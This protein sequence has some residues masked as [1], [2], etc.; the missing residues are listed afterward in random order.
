VGR[1]PHPPPVDILLTFFLLF[2]L[3]TATILP[4]LP[5][6]CGSYPVNLP[7]GM[8][9]DITAD[10]ATQG[11]APK[12]P[13]PSTKSAARTKKAAAA[14][15]ADRPTRTRTKTAT[16]PSTKTTQ[17]DNL[18][19]GPSSSSSDS[20]TSEDP[21][22]A[23]QS[24]PE[25]EDVYHPTRQER[26]LSRRSGIGPCPGPTSRRLQV[27]GSHWN[28]F[29]LPFVIRDADFNRYM[30]NCS[31]GARQEA[32]VLYTATAV[33]GLQL[34][35]CYEFLES[36]PKIGREAREHLE[37]NWTYDF[38]IHEYL[39]VRLGII[40]GLQGDSQAQALAEIQQAQVR[41]LLGRGSISA[42]TYQIYIP[43]DTRAKVF[44]ATSRKPRHADNRGPGKSKNP[45]T[46]SPGPSL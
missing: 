24:D 9:D 3:P 11:S 28:S 40:E 26:T 4:G 37:E 41:P 7:H 21:N 17:L 44:A 15:K 18:E 29:P 5:N 16:N 8:T 38:G 30:S 32:E 45:K 22:D 27:P 33:L 36:H 25:Y 43:A 35:R 20:T 10:V 2:S 34:N 42:E 23:D 12:T 14:E 39:L 46:K 6:A 1:L 13:N 31:T 19:S